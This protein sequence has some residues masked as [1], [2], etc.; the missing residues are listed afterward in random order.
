VKWREVNC[1][2]DMKG[3]ERSEVEWRED[4][5]EMWAHHNMILRIPLLLLFSVWYTYFL[6]TLIYLIVVVIVFA[7]Y[8]LCVVCPLLFV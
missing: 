5:G 6:L 7:L 8:S 1:G 3:V 2:E 4:H